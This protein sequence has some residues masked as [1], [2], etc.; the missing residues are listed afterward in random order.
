[1]ISDKLSKVGRRIGKLTDLPE[2]LKQ[3][4]QITK[5]DQVEDQ[6]LT[7]M[8]EELDGIANIDEILV[9][10]YRRFQVIFKRQL[11]ANKL[12]RMAKLNWLYP[13]PGKK[14]IYSLEEIPKS[15]AL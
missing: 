7:V 15:N 13:V 4:L 12:Y 6:I 1:M 14:G 2:E 9:C 5:G 10:L 11:L 8:Q 3:Q